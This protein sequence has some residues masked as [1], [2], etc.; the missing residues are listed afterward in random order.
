MVGPSRGR[1]SSVAALSLALA[2]LSLGY[3]LVLVGGANGLG[4]MNA[5]PGSALARLWPDAFTVLS[6]QVQ[7]HGEAG[8]ATALAANALIPPVSGATPSPPLSAEVFGDAAEVSI[9]NVPTSTGVSWVL[10]RAVPALGVGLI[11]WLLFRIARDHGR[12]ESFSTRA[13]KRLRIIGLLLGVGG[14]L[15]VLVRWLVDRSILERSTAAEIAS[16]AP[17]SIPLW[18]VVVGLAVLM[19]ATFVRRATAMADDLEGLV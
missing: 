4:W 1:Y 7:V 9:W 19:A 13:A 17:L 3:A 6:L 2:T 16:I 12:G 5:G 18:P 8:T 10:A 15:S 14:P 11:W